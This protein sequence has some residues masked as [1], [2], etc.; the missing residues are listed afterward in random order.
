MFFFAHSSRENFQFVA[1]SA[2]KPKRSFTRSFVPES[3]A[4]GSGVL[5]RFHA[6]F[7]IKAAHFAKR[8]KKSIYG[9]GCYLPTARRRADERERDGAR[10]SI[11]AGL[12]GPRGDIKGSAW[13]QPVYKENCEM[14]LGAGGNP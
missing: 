9:P 1:F 14:S 11:S 8:K 10:S 4:V 3:R 6:L 13:R 2:P 12:T 5:R 7:A